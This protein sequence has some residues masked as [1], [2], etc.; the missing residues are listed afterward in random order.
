MLS[1]AVEFTCKNVSLLSKVPALGA[2]ATGYGS[3]AKMLVQ[4]KSNKKV[5]V[6]FF[7]FYPS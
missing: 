6:S 3:C 5:K 1:L 7:M 2:H 4:S